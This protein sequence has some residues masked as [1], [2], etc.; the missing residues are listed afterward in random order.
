MNIR[1]LILLSF[2]VLA[3]L[4]CEAQNQ[5]NY[6]KLFKDGEA[7]KRPMVF[8]SEDSFEEIKENGENIYF[9]SNHERF[10]YNP[11]IHSYFIVSKKRL[12]NLNI[13][14]P[15][16]LYELEE[17]EY[18][19]KA[20]MIKKDLGVKPVPPID[21]SILKI[22]ILRKRESNYFAYEVKWL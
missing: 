20:N 21:H 7:Y 18:K 4:S 13:Q 15:V 9:I 16:D 22:F 2:L 10:L 8:L 1:H 19:A 14:Q 6:Y 5:G 12:E 17:N 3:S 11:Q